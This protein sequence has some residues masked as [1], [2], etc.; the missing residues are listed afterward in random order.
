MCINMQVLVEK[1]VLGSRFPN[2]LF[3]A[4]TAAHN[5]T[6]SIECGWI[7]NVE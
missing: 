4:K 5:S 3:T 7:Q 6:K 2:V 1:W